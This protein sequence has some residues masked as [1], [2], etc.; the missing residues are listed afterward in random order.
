MSATVTLT[1]T[2]GRLQG[3]AFVF[4]DA[5]QCMVGRAADCG[6]ALPNDAAH[7]DVSRH[8]CRFEID[9][10]TIRVRDLG[11]RNGTYLNGQKIGQRDKL[12]PV[13]AAAP[14][15]FPDYDLKENDEI[16]VGNTIFRVHISRLAEAEAYS[17]E[18][19]E[20]QEALVG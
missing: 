11:S 12:L 17:P 9:P 19:L 3:E 18:A 10:P 15:D 6:L 4:R 14:V 7:W 16:R 5:T 1:I 2:K 13:E 8:H 20:D